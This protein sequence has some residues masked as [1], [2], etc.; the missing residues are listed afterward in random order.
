MSERK[1]IIKNADM[2]EDMQQD[3]LD[4]ATQGMV[5]I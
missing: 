4:C 2:A 5:Q 3:A 1:A